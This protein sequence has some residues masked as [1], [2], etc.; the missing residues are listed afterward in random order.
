MKIAVISD[1]HGNYDALVAVLKKAKQVGVEHLLVLGDIVGYY[2]HPEKILKALSEW[3]FDMIKGNHEYI[4]EDLIAEPSLGASIRLKYG[5]G[6]KEAVDKLSLQQLDFLKDLPETKSVK[7][8]GISFLMSHGS[9]W[10]NDY[11]IYPDCDWAT[12]KKCDSIKHDF[13]LIG[14][15]HYAFAF[16][17]ENSILINPG[18][19]GQS[20]QIGGKASWCIVNTENRCFQMISTD[21]NVQNLLSEIAE[22]DEDILYLKKVLMRNQD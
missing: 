22:K 1:I 17:N 10:S 15:S 2:Y 9:P 13:V 20:R 5:S 11:Y 8:D 14:H 18:S 6:H 19:V 3:S 12:V 21:Y 4:L 16:N 7:F